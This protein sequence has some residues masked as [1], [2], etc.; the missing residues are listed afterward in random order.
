MT[1]KATGAEKQPGSFLSWASAVDACLEHAQPASVGT[2][3][4]ARSAENVDVQAGSEGTGDA[5]GAAGGEAAQDEVVDG[6][7][8]I[9]EAV[10]VAEALCSG[11]DVAF[12]SLTEEDLRFYESALL[13]YL[14]TLELGVRERFDA[15]VADESVTVDHFLYAVKVRTHSHFSP[16]S[17]CSC[18]SLGPRMRVAHTAVYTPTHTQRHF[19]RVVYLSFS[20]VCSPCVSKLLV[21][22]C[23][24]RMLVGP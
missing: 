15:M 11:E 14:D 13:D 9:S 20:P 7:A 24:R 10:K 22:V 6:E 12:S 8:A 3:S 2:S 21:F 5:S 16:P 1:R 17:L 18:A 19:Q 4:Q 23:V